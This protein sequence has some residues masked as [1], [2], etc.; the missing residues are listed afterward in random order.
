MRV[1]RQKTE[2][3]TRTHGDAI[4]VEDTAAGRDKAV[5]LGPEE[6]VEVERGDGAREQAQGGVLRVAV[7][8]HDNNLGPGS[9]VVCLDLWLCERVRVCVCVVRGCDNGT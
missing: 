2:A 1:R 7:V 8:R 6:L 9:I 3:P 5:V 4:A